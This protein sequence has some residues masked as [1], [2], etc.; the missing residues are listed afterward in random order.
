VL[1]G[2]DAADESRQQEQVGLPIESR[3]S[4]QRPAPPDQA[5]R[6][7]SVRDRTPRDR[8]CQVVLRC[9]RSKVER[10]SIPLDLGACPGKQY[11]LLSGSKTVVTH[12]SSPMCIENYI[13]DIG[14]SE[15]F[16][17]VSNS[18]HGSLRR[19]LIRLFVLRVG[20]LTRKAPIR[21]PWVWRRS[22]RSE[23]LSSYSD[24]I[25]SLPAFAS[26]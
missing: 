8:R 9:S 16:M 19:P 10:N 17:G 15:L 14:K 11:S 23:S 3:L 18:I 25:S 5:R 7:V 21:T 24:A 6:D 1:D 20:L 26:I 22:C 13:G 2:R 4:R 12:F